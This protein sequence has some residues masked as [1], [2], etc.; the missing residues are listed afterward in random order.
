MHAAVCS[1][2]SLANVVRVLVAWL[3]CCRLCSALHA[4]VF[5]PVS[6]DHY[7]RSSTY[8]FVFKYAGYLMV[9]A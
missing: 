6:S 4:A 1:F 9:V 3:E 8:C 7:Q 5:E 2:V